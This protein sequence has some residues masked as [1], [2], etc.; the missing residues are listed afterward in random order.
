MDLKSIVDLVKEQ[1]KSIVWEDIHSVR[2]ALQE[3]HRVVKEVLDLSHLK[4][5]FNRLYGD[6]IQLKVHNTVFKRVDVDLLDPLASPGSEEFQKE[7]Y[8][9]IKRNGVKD[10]FHLHF[11]TNTPI[12]H[13]HGYLIKTGNNRV[14]VCKKLGIKEVP[15]IVT[16]LSGEC[17]GSGNYNEPFVEGEI[18]VTEADVRRHYFT[19]KVEITFRDGQIINSYTPYFLRQKDIYSK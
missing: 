7:L 15:C 17:F 4:K 12:G 11:V 14:V 1:E 16:N 13:R 18:L 2:S 6:M 19:P 9:S 10:P 3:L 8:E 5:T